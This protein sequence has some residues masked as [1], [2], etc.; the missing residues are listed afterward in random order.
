MVDV[1]SYVLFDVSMSEM[2]KRVNGDQRGWRM[3]HKCCVN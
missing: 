3:R 2:N 1:K